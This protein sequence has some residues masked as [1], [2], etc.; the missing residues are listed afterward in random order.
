MNIEIN[1]ACT[2]LFRVDFTECSNFISYDLRP[3]AF[4]ILYVILANRKLLDGIRIEEIS[5]KVDFQTR[6]ICIQ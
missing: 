6:Y 3:Y 5:F 1:T 4:R 2:R